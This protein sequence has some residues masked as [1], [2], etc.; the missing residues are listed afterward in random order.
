M[1]SVL[2]ILTSLFCLFKVQSLVLNQ[3]EF[4]V[5]VQIEKYL[6]RGWVLIY[7]IMSGCVM[8]SL[9]ISY[10]LSFFLGS[11]LLNAV[12]NYLSTWYK[13]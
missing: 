7:G 3:V 13:I 10:N 1:P 2:A 11:N 5:F 9:L 12:G 4:I 6:K 8:S